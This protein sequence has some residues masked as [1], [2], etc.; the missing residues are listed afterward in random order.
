MAKTRP[1]PEVPLQAASKDKGGHSPA[2]PQGGGGSSS[3]KS[4]H[5]VRGGSASM[6]GNPR[7]CVGSLGQRCKHLLRVKGIA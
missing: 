4:R 2:S 3:I 7:N 5:Q 6:F 1:H